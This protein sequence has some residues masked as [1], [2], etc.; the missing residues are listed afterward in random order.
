MCLKPRSSWLFIEM[1]PLA[2]EET[3]ELQLF[4]F[5]AEMSNEKV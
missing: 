5:K 2:L 3:D 1:A 4:L